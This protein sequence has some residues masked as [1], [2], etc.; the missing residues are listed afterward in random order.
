MH[1][2]ST[3]SILPRFRAIVFDLDDTLYLEGDYV[4]SGFRAVADELAL[5]LALSADEAFNELDALF[6]GGEH[7][8]TFDRWVEARGLGSDG[9]VAE[10][11][12]VYRS[13]RP[14]MATFPGVPELLGRL[15]AD[16]ALGLLSDGYEDVQRKKL[17]AL[18]IEGAFQAVVFSDSVGR[19]AWKPS[20]KPYHAILAALGVSGPEAV[21]V[22]DNPLKDFL[23]ARRVDMRS[24]RVRVPGGVYRELEPETPDHAADADLTSLSD[25]ESLL[26]SFPN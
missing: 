11:I 5:R 12:D 17:E 25:L 4:R 22:S 26:L 23:G 13:H 1:Y 19:D 10:L 15:G 7:R 2:F 16:Y 9:L 8:R 24:I 14:T 18:A 3:R 6:Q 20:P 21:Y